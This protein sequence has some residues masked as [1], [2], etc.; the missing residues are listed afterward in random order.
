MSRPL[1]LV[2]AGSHSPSP[3]KPALSNVEG[4]RA[5][6]EKFYR[7]EPESC[8]VAAQGDDVGGAILAYSYT[9]EHGL[10]LFIQELFV[11]NAARKH[12]HGKALVKKLRDRFA[13]ARVKITPLVKADTSVL[14]FYNSLGFEKDK[15]VSFSFDE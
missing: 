6:V 9:R 2:G 15:A 11:S 4:A 13:K 5:Y 14:N 3:R 10:V 1:L 8:H 12:G 7:F